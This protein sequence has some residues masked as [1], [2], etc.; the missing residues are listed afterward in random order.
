MP[1]NIVICCDG[2]GNT[3]SD[4]AKT[5]VFKLYQMLLD[6]ETQCSLYI[7]GLG[8]IGYEDTWLG[9][10]QYVQGLHSLATGSG[11]DKN[12][13]AAYIFLCKMYKPGD[14]VWLFGFSRGAY[15]M[16]VLAA[17]TYVVGLLSPNQTK[18]AGHAFTIFKRSSVA[19]RSQMDRV[20]NL[21][22]DR[23][24]GAYDLGQS[25]RSTPINFEF[26]GLW[27]PV[28]SVIVPQVFRPSF[29][30]VRF[31]NSNSSIKVMRLAA[32]ID[33][34]RRHYRLHE[35][36]YGQVT[37]SIPAGS[38]FVLQDFK[39]TWFAGCHSDVGGGVGIEPSLS[40]Y[41]LD[42]MVREA[43]SCGLKI[44][45]EMYEKNIE[46]DNMGRS[47]GWQS[48]PV[49]GSVHN[50]MNYKWIMFELFPKRSKWREW[51]RKW[52]V[53]G[54]YMPLSEPRCIPKAASIHWSALKLLEQSPPYKPTNL[55]DR[56][57][58]CPGLS[59]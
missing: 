43:C 7:P 36:L 9:S 54:L 37:R 44:D 27:D 34:R 59:H 28:A 51:A 53:L 8:T 10:L 18:L 13:I 5:N 22:P 35:W 6:D 14:R 15:S 57:E 48:R 55:T 49:V 45:M 42:W 19:A 38:P 24:A 17:F 32:S 12:V 58:S 29:D 3:I 26:V 2:T 46:G 1:K 33:E 56:P 21:P 4:A 11:L 39:K 41:P 40:R 23:L 16:L 30:Q 31:T 52:K 50:S 47:S 20:V 25:L